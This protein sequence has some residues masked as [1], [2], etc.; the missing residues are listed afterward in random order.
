[1]LRRWT[2][3]RRS[4]VGLALWREQLNALLVLLLEVLVDAAGAGAGRQQPLQGWRGRALT[5]AAGWRPV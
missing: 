1:M 2:R 4:A 3:L 5:G